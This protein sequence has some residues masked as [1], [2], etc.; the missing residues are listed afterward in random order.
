MGKINI[1]AMGAIFKKEYMDTIRNRWLMVITLIFL[2]L[3]VVVSYFNSSNSR[4]VGFQNLDD[5]VIALTSIVSLLVP[6]VAIMLGHSSIIKERENNSLSTLLSYPVNR[7]EVF[8]GKYVALAAVLFT[9]IFIG[10]G[11]AGIVISM[12]SRTGIASYFLHF[13]L[14]TFLMGLIFL[15]I[16]MLI[17]VTVKKRSVAVG[18][19]VFTWFFFS[20]I[21]SMLLTGLY[22]ATEG[23][24]HSI[25]S[26]EIGPSAWIWKA[27]FISPI[28]T[29]QMHA[30]LIYGVKSVF[31]IAVPL[32][33]SYINMWTTLVG[34]SAWAAIPL[35]IAIILFSRKDL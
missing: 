20:M 29:Y 21:I 3:A 33:P 30:I 14:I 9:T 31:G 32:L 1:A 16:S 25:F 22:A 11:G 7:I 28:D 19:G 26:G 4:G 8:V 24:Y 10:F 34:L 23:N 15:G 17:S 13:L 2:L 27:M 5:T 18:A 35:I 6:M 12:G